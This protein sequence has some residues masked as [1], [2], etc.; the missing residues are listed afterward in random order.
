[1][2]KHHSLAVRLV[3]GLLLL[4]VAAAASAPATHLS[5]TAA[6]VARVHHCAEDKG[7][8]GKTEQLTE[9]A[10]TVTDASF[11]APAPWTKREWAAMLLTIG[12]HESHFSMRIIAGNCKPHECDGGKA[13]GAFQQHENSRNER[14]WRDL[15]GNLPLQV[16]LASDE[17]KRAWLTCKN[18]NQP[19]FEATVNAYAGKACNADW[20]GL[21]ARRDT[22]ERLLRTPDP[23]GGAS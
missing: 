7:S 4:V 9:L 14:V 19:R 8:E 5:W 1:M 22:Y 3:L 12:Q 13:S 20:P 11:K 10:A 16:S 21:R 6:A 17:L 18:T 2:K 23:K 15:P